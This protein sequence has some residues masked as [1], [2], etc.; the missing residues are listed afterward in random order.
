MLV[1]DSAGQLGTMSSSGRY[2]EEIQD[3]GE[4]SSGLMQLRPVTFRYTEANA[5]NNRPV[6]PGLI[7]EEVAEVFPG[8]VVRGSDGKIHSVQ[9]HKLIPMLLNELQKQEQLIEQQQAMIADI[10]ER[11]P[12]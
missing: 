6:Q 7:A 2:K 10:L 9:Y 8:L 1:I 5:G 3:M 12:L 11:L 4:N